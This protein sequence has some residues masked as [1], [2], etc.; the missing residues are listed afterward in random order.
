MA[1]SERPNILF[2]MSDQHRHDYVGCAG[3]KF[4][5][6]PN[7]DSLAARGVRFTQCC[8]NAPLCTPARIGLASGL[9]PSRLG[10][11]D[12]ESF[13]PRSV[14]TYYQRLRDAGYRV[15]C[16]GK[17]D[18]A[19]PDEYNGR[20]G[21]RPC[22]FGWGFT[23][24]EEVEGKMHA[25]TS[26]TPR[27]PY[28][29]MLEAKG[30][31]AKFHHDYA[32]RRKNG[33][34]IGASHDSVLPTE[35]FADSYIGRRAA[36]WIRNVD[37]DFPWHLFVSFAGPHDPFD[38]PAE[39][40]SRYRNAEMPVPISDEMAG[41]PRWIAQRRVP[42]TPE[43]IAE[44]RRQYCA[45][46]ELID[47]EIGRILSVLE[48]RGASRNTYVFYS[49]DHGEMLGDHGLYRKICAYESA[50]R[51]PLL[52]AGPGIAGGRI[53]DALIEMA[54][55]NPT[56]CELAGLPAQERI[57]ARSFAPVLRQERSAHRT[58]TIAALREFRCIRTERHK[59][60]DNYNDRPELYDLAEDAE[61]LNNIGEDAKTV[62]RQLLARLTDRL[63]EGQWQR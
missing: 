25:G 29:L 5:R 36:E 12:N 16:V 3:A 56:I 45:S 38:P 51:V 52:A 33:W 31:Y 54:D 42:A 4:I 32:E 62:R 57:D 60:I 53:S 30:L 9:Q 48:N 41:K 58:E 61:E 43:Q 22:V 23:H 39:Y 14:T 17:L 27:G 40:A 49:S 24:P 13:L 19:K 26:P 28:G 63:S 55:V 20:D 47:A 8:S 35:D 15:G 59:L 44:T 7:L 10:S 50:L 18:L 2:I 34:L 11:L 6:T 21:D 46:T 37:D 1:A